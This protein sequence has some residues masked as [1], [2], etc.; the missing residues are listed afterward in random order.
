MVS[1]KTRDRAVWALEE[2]LSDLEYRQLHDIF[3]G[4]SDAEFRLLK[5]KIRHAIAELKALTCGTQ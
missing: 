4:R 3:D 2:G 5:M 1:R